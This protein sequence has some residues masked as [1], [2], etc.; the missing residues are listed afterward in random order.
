M[1]VLSAG[2]KSSSRTSSA[3]DAAEVAYQLGVQNLRCRGVR[4]AAQH[5]L[6]MPR[7]A[8]GT[9]RGCLRVYR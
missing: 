6:H 8:R 9:L 4:A 5:P 3:S 1:D 2:I 7:R